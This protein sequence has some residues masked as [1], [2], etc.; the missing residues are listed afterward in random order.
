MSGF[1]N[2][3]QS[4]F[5]GGRNSHSTSHKNNKKKTSEDSAE[6]GG[7]EQYKVH[8]ATRSYDDIVLPEDR[9]E[10]G[11][12]DYTAKATSPELCGSRIHQTTFQKTINQ[13]KR[14]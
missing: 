4:L 10:K 13:Q 7:Q 9:E 11:T 6:N 2:K 14:Q 8:K 3:L 12:V 1:W 5:G